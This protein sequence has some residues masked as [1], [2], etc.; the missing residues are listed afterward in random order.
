MMAMIT[1]LTSTLPSV[2]TAIIADSLGTLV[3][4]DSVPIPAIDPDMVLVK[5]Q[6]VAVNPVDV[7]SADNLAQPGATSGFDFA[8]IVIAIGSQVSRVAIGDRVCGSVHG[9]NKDR[10]RD[11]AFA[12]YVGTLADMTLKIPT[13]MSFEHAATLATG[14]GTVGLALRSLGLLAQA[15]PGEKLSSVVLVYGGSTATGTLAL[16]LLNQ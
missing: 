15:E 13:D 7:K 12:Q 11:G 2:Q 6:A 4:S 9:M 16:Q 1:P 14:L 10:P 5:N 3:V 8:G